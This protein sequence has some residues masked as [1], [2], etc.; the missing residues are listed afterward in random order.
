MAT[1]AA[2]LGADTEFDCAGAA[3]AGDFAIAAAT[4]SLRIRPPIPVPVTC[5]RS[6]PFSDANF[7]TIGVT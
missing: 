2:A 1:G 7:R 4:S 5:E 6:T 3:A